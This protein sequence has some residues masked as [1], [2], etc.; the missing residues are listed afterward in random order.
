MRKSGSTLI[1]REL[2]TFLG[3][4]T[5]DEQA[6]RERNAHGDDDKQ[7]HRR[8]R[9]VAEG[10]E[11]E[12]STVATPPPSRG[13]TPATIAFARPPSRSSAVRSLTSR[14]ALEADVAALRNEVRELRCALSELQARHTPPQR[15]R[16]LAALSTALSYVKLWMSVRA[17]WFPSPRARAMLMK[18]VAKYGRW[19]RIVVVSML[20]SALHLGQRVVPAAPVVG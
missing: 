7:L 2:E 4:S 15:N 13:T 17:L 9:W 11:L 14:D 16:L 19:L 1:D 5:A 3:G 6:L 18:H 10:G 8:P 12:G 20:I